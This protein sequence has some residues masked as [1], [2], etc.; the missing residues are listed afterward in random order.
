MMKAWFLY[1]T[2][3][4]LYF[5][6]GIVVTT[7][8]E[9]E[10]E[11]KTERKKEKKT[12]GEKRHCEQTE[13]WEWRENRRHLAQLQLV[14]RRGLSRRVETHKQGDDSIFVPRHKVLHGTQK[15]LFLLPGSAAAARA[16]DKLRL[17]FGGALHDFPLQLL[18]NRSFSPSCRHTQFSTMVQYVRR[19]DPLIGVSIRKK[20]MTNV[21][22]VF[23]A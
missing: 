13:E 21:L 11:R 5:N 18:S 4:M 14:Q 8:K 9:R 17:R 23:F 1:S 3:S 15:P 7:C 12:D 10:R 16:R 19:V 20:R 6:V 22:L 2:D